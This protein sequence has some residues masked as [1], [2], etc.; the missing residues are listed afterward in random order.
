M[1]TLVITYGLMMISMHLLC[2]LMS[3]HGLLRTCRCSMNMLVIRY[4]LMMIFMHFMC[5][6]VNFHGPLRTCRCFTNTWM[7]TYGLMMT[8]MHVCIGELPQPVK[9]LQVFCEHISDHLWT[10]EYFHASYAC[11][12]HKHVLMKT[13]KFFMCISVNTYGLMRTYKCFM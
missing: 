12:N 8:S 5:V 3:F 2:V 11:F 6:L 13:L 10:N 4:G 9:D 1:N 7:I